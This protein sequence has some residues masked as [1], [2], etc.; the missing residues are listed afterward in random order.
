MASA[1]EVLGDLGALLEKGRVCGGTL[2]GSDAFNC[3]PLGGTLRFHG[4]RTPV[5]A[6]E[7][8]CPGENGTCGLHGV[9]PC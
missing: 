3:H 6:G 2:V 9:I 7:A 5:P 1:L 4:F 8:S